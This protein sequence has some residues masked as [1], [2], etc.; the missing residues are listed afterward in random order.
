M[1]RETMANALKVAIIGV[2]MVG[3]PLAEL[4]ARAGHQVFVSSR[5]PEQL[6]A[7]AG[8]FKGNVLDAVNFADAILLAIPLSAVPKLPD[9]VKNAMR[10]KV[11]LDANNAWLGREGE[12]AAEA[13]G[14]I[15]C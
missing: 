15:R 2:G 13:H 6:V 14:E 7:P 5:H 12:A 4:W 9:D 10:G 1:L 8:G 3:G 11:L